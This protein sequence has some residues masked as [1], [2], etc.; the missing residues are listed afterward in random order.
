MAAAVFCGLFINAAA[1][2]T[3]AGLFPD[4][5]AAIVIDANS[6]KI[7]FSDKADMRRYP[8]SLTK[9]MTLYLLFDAMRAGKVNYNTRI[10]ISAHAHAQPPTKLNIGIGQTITAEDAAKAIVTK[11]AN[12]V[13][14]AIGEY[15]GGSERNFARMM[16][17]QARRLGMRNTNF[18]NASGLPNPDNYSTARDLAILALDLR[19]QFPQQYWLFNTTSFI[20]KGHFIRGHNRLLATMDGV[21]GLKTGYT[22]MSGFNLASS[23]R[24]GNKSIVAVVMGGKTSALR[25]SYMAGLLIR[26]MDK[27]S[28]KRSFNITPP[29]AP[30]T[31][32][33][34]A[35]ATPA[36]GRLK[37]KSGSAL[38]V[39]AA[40]SLAAANIPI[41]IAKSSVELASVIAASEGDIAEDDRS[42]VPLPQTSPEDKKSAESA[43]AEKV[44]S[45]S[46]E[47]SDREH[48]SVMLAMLSSGMGDDMPPS[49]AEQAADSQVSDIDES[50]S[51]VDEGQK[52]Q[53]LDDVITS[54]LPPV[55]HS[56]M[57]EPENTEKMK[58]A[59]KVRGKKGWAIQLAAGRTAGEARKAVR[60]TEPAVRKYNAQAQPY[61]EKQ[62][63]RRAISYRLRYNGFPTKMAARQACAGVKKSGYKKCTVSAA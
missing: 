32:A 30:D 15:L 14:V 53:T 36:Q 27:G 50:L 20:C 52:Q 6:G 45:S 21:D 48:D 58:T 47:A 56:A 59:G 9:M 35:Q 19:R 7:L 39:E 10:P 28:G 2:L 26:Y 24:M 41:P 31:G 17:M 8:A 13:A 44:E 60:K 16:T 54:S 38:A 61:I 40:T 23:R 1:A 34:M 63:K 37:L 4:K 33:L 22:Q 11:S 51:S 49:N 25:D 46:D 29:A 57:S 62:G 3:P 43:T 12:D 42:A 5:Y 18:A 55:A